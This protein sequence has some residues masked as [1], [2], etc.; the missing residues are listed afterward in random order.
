[1]LAD[2]EVDMVADVV[3]G[4]EVDMVADMEVDMMANIVATKFFRPNFLSQRLPPACAF[5]ALWVHFKANQHIKSHKTLGTKTKCDQ[6]SPDRLGMSS[7]IFPYFF[8]AT[9]DLR[10]AKGSHSERRTHQCVCWEQT[11][12]LGRSYLLLHYSILR[13]CH[14]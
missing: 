10:S 11:F 3:Y 2:M 8:T 5:A 7:S 14:T 1:M 6:L 4:M 9:L 12:T 13:Q